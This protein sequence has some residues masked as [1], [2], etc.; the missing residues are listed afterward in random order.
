MKK[1]I[2]LLVLISALLFVIPTGEALADGN[3]TL[4]PPSIP[5]ASGTGIVAA[6]TGLITPPGTINLNVPLGASIKQ[7]LLYWEQLTEEGLGIPSD[8]IEVDGV[9]ITGTLIGISG[10]SDRLVY[11]AD[12]TGLV[13]PGPNSF[14]VVGLA[15]PPTINDGAGILVIIDDGSGASQIELRDG[16]D[17]AW[18]PAPS[19]LDTTVPQTFIFD[20]APIERVA[21]LDM[22]FASVSGSASGGGF[23]PSAIEITID[24]STSVFDNILDSNDGDEWDTVNLD[25]PIPAGATS[26]TVQALS[27]DNDPPD[28]GPGGQPEGGEASFTWI[29]AGLAVPEIT[30]SIDIRKQAE[31]PDSRTFPSG[32]DVTFEIVVTN[33]GQADLS[34]VEVT[35]VEA[36]GCANSIGD[37][38]AGDSVSYICTAPNVTASFENEACVEGTADGIMVVDCD[39]STVEIID[40][41]IRK[42]EEGPDTRTFPSG[43]DV[44]FEIVVTNTGDEDLEN[45]VVTDILVPGCGRIIGDL[46]AGASVSYTCT[47][48]NVTEGFVNE[49]CVT[50]ERNGVTLEDCD[51]SNVEIEGGGEGCTPGYWKQSQHFDSW[52]APLTPD[53]PFSDVF[54]NAFPGKTLL[55]VLKQG[56][57][58]L[59]ALGRHTVAALLN[60]ASPNVSYDLSVAD[61]IDQFNAV[62]PG[63]KN[64]YNLLKNSFESFNEQ[65]C[66]LN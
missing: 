29:T 5:I 42:Q 55:Q 40:I 49:A 48:P 61:V 9:S 3:E 32:S 30:P 38:A 51:P 17:F 47:A 53:T 54:E 43:S 24:G 13:N 10:S 46:A 44:P 59:K 50:G 34:N 2:A 21:T 6:G 11:R 20:P 15:S 60:A 18:A 58:G 28:T 25:I 12:I 65:G 39:P 33:T 63:T 16:S 66:P 57:G 8:T 35:D 4:G 36:P 52:T 26:L 27:V 41:D 19:P 31:G 62:F 56:G 7:A 14:E 64:A 45:V 22:F 37:L 23:R 1:S